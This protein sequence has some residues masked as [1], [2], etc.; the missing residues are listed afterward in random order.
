MEFQSTPLFGGAITADLPVTFQDVSTIRQIPDTQEVYL[1]QTGYTSLLFDI[2]ERV[3][4]P[5]EDLEALKFHLGEIVEED[6]GEV[7]VFEEGRGVDLPGLVGVKAF[8]LSARAPPGEKMRGRAHEPREVGI[9]VL[10]VR[11]EG[12]GTDL[13]VTVN[14]PVGIVDDSQ[15]QQSGD[16]GRLMEEGKE[17]L[18]RVRRSLEVKD[19]GLFVGDE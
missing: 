12:V 7:R 11:L 16:D 4:E 2:L 1:A 9:L 6:V 10:L 13:V 3:T 5:E 14:V 8:T 19:W 17:V 15:G 18:E